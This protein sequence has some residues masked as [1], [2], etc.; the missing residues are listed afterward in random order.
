MQTPSN[1]T[2]PQQKK[3]FLQTFQKGCLYQ[4]SFGNESDF[5]IRSLD[6]QK[7]LDILNSWVNM[8]YAISFWQ[9]DGS[10]EKLHQT[11]T[12]ILNAPDA[13]SFIGCINGRPVCQLDAYNP[14]ADVVG[15]LYDCRPGDLGIHLLLTPEKIKISNFSARI[16]ESFCNWFF[17]AYPVSRIIAEPDI[18]NRAANLLLRKLNFTF[19]GIIKMPEKTAGLYMLEKH[20]WSQKYSLL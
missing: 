6:L 11:Y 5:T 14:L 16:V 10:K 3:Y 19:S 4:Q 13:H 7:D 1:T 2:A 12:N 18:R 8:D 15:T 17:T 9:M 20:H